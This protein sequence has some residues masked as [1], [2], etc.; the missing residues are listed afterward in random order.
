VSDRD[1]DDARHYQ[2]HR[3]DAEEWGEPVQ[4]EPKKRRLG[5]MLSV[6][7]TP[8]EAERVREAASDA[9]QSLSEFLRA[10]ILQ[11]ATRAP[12]IEFTGGSVTP[13]AGEPV[14]GSAGNTSSSGTAALT[15]R[16]HPD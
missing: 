15:T 3:D 4:P 13:P 16:P 14:E 8:E 1:E 11:H 7:L 10:A 9:G 12:S 2:A 6:R 5:A